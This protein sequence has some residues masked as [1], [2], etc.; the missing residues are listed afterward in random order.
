MGNQ[1]TLHVSRSNWWSD[2]NYQGFDSLYQRPVRVQFSLDVVLTLV[3]VETMCSTPAFGRQWKYT[4]QGWATCFRLN[5]TTDK[6]AS[7]FAQAHQNFILTSNKCQCRFSVDNWGD[8]TMK[9]YN[10]NTWSF[11]WQLVSFN[12]WMSSA[13]FTE[14]TWC[15]WYH[16]LMR[17]PSSWEVG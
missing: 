6:T 8:Q 15:I 11:T 3:G 4:H 17:N 14:N 13:F 2:D 7:V 1:S 12:L 9:S 10:I 5:Y 16:F